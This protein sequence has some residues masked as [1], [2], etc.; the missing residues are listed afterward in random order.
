MRPANVAGL[1]VA[2][3][4]L[5]AGNHR[6]EARC[7]VS[8]RIRS[9]VRPSP[10]APSGSPAGSF[11]TTDTRIDPPHAVARTP[12]DAGAP[13]A[14]DP[15]AASPDSRPLEPLA[16]DSQPD[17][18][19]RSDTEAGPLPID[20]E[21]LRNQARQLAVHLAA[22]QAD[23]DRR[24]AEYQGLVARRENE[25]RSAR[26]WFD[27]R[28]EEWEERR[29][30]L[31]AREKEL[32]G[33]YAQMKS[34]E[35]AVGRLGSEIESK[36]TARD[37]ELTRRE[38]AVQARADELEQAALVAAVETASQ[39]NAALE[40]E[41]RREEFHREIEAR[42][43]EVL[44]EKALLSNEAE[45]LELARAELERIREAPSE[46]QRRFEKQ[47]DERE[48][49]LR[50]RT[51]EVERQE[52][53]ARQSVID[54]ERASE[55]VAFEREQAAAQ[56]RCDRS[57]LAELRR[58]VEAELAEKRQVIERQ[59]EQLDYR[60]A[61]VRREQEDLAAAQ[62]EVLEHRL[63]LEELRTQLSGM[64]PPAALQEQIARLRSRLNEHYRMS[65]DELAARQAE[66]AAL[67]ADLATES[68][69]LGRQSRE[70][71]DWAEARNEEIERQA[72]FLTRREAELERQSS[73]LERRGR[74]WRQ[75]RL[76]LEQELRLARLAIDDFQTAA[77]AAERG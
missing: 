28:R 30:E 10:D 37:E 46:F 60:R 53:L 23:L 65:H 70:L 40:I 74:V 64:V 42:R 62:R 49:E 18:A 54:A 45:R 56:A 55:A 33:R 43:E 38:A 73:E 20:V 63:A 71:R 39:R 51:A 72:A 48:A 32:E 67:R 27:H 11:P 6:F 14:H 35:E 13:P 41:A 8:K 59:S 61:A 44:C 3:A 58:R 36:L 17:D 2:R 29:E 15:A 4:A 16:H 26:L 1:F 66:L 31:A 50:A 25:V 77:T 19:L 5:P 57:E 34:A 22:K 76:Q 21:M 7:R 52:Q 75:E 12:A 68:D 9:S 47:L 69:R 24:E